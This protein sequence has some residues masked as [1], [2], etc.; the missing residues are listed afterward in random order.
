MRRLSDIHVVADGHHAAAYLCIALPG[1]STH[2]VREMLPVGLEEQLQT[3]AASGLLGQLHLI[4]RVQR[5]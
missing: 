2:L 1:A 3:L 4:V 5:F